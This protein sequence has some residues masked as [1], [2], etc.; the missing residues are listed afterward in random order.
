MT[1][2]DAASYSVN[3]DGCLCLMSRFVPPPLASQVLCDPLGV[4]LL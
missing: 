1:R 2:G 3:G 4:Y